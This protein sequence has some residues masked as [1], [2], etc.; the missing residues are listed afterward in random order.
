MSSWRDLHEGGRS[1]HDELDAVAYVDDG[2]LASG[3][4]AV[5]ID[6]EHRDGHTLEIVTPYRIKRL[7]RGVETG[8]MS[9]SGG[10][11]RIWP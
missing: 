2:R 1:R 7:G 8:Q 10:V 6:L 4:D 5:R 11:R 9:V 3:S